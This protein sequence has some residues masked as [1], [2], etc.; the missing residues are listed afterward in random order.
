MT[1][2]I[3]SNAGELP[4]TLAIDGKTIPDHLGW[5][6]S[7]VNAVVTGASLHCQHRTSHVI[8]PE[9]GGDYVFQIRG[10]QPTLYAF[11]QS[12]LAD[13]PPLCPQSKA[14]TDD[15]YPGSI[16]RSSRMLK[17][18]TFQKPDV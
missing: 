2:W 9:K 18:V 17:C 1:L 10:N 13:E 4:R 12:Q 15:T 14:A 11:A 5:I 16:V 6:V 7:L 8:T 3:Q